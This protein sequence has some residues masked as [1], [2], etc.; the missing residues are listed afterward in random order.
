MEENH[1][2]LAIAEP[3]ESGKPICEMKAAD[4]PL[5]IDHVRYFA[6][7]IRAQERTRGEIDNDT[8]AYHFHEL[9]GVVGQIIPWDFPI[10]MAVRKRARAVAAGNAVSQSR[11]RR[12]GHRSSS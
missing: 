1:E 5:A 8:I 12:P 4:I 10:L 2:A 11:L 6:L 9:L 3:W 7:A